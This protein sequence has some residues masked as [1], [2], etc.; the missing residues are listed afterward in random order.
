MSVADTSLWNLTVTEIKS[1]VASIRPTPGGGSVSVITASLGLALLHKGTSVSLKKPAADAGKHQSLD[2]LRMK[3]VGAM[4]SLSRLAD[5]D[6][7]AFQSYITACSLPHTGEEETTAREISMAGALL[8][9]TQIPIESATEMAQ[10]LAL[11]ETAVGLA[12][13]IVLSDLFAGAL[14]LHASLKAVLL[15][16]EANLPGIKDAELRETLKHRRIALE[17]EA[18]RRADAIADM[19]RL[20]VRVVADY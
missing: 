19:Y 2:E 9:A 4:D 15:N 20:R 17:D 6:A 12:E 8:R 7:E 18:A 3:L 13:A 14:L 1:R 10:G 16:V 11:A 5:E